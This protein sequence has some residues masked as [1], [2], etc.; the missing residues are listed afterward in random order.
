MDKNQIEEMR[1]PALFRAY[2]GDNEQYMDD[3]WNWFIWPHIK[4]FD[5]SSVADIACGKGRNTRK[6]I[7]AGQS[8]EIWL[9]DINEEAIRSCQDR[10]QTV[11]DPKIHYVL[12][13]G[14]NVTQIPD[15]RLSLIYSWDSMVHFDLPVI[16]SYFK[17]FAR[18][19]Q[20]GGMGY[21]HH[22]NF[23]NLG[24]DPHWKNNPGWRSNVTAED[25]R[26]LA[27]KNGLTVLKQFFIEWDYVKDSDC[28]T[29]FQKP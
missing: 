26:A 24:A 29:L 27:E 6:F 4:D 11:T 19:L 28:V 13:D 20:S 14:E 22:S 2:Y 8:K 17:E 15:Q 25:I 9:V 23:G 3:Q 12:V 1:N 21:I 7:E 5:L 18:M 10:F 16:A